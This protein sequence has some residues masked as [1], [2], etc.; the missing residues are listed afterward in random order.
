M[1]TW[2]RLTGAR[3]EEGR[4]IWWKEGEGISQRTRMNDSWA[5]TMERGLWARGVEWVEGGREK[6]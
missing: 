5:W 6:H 3:G 1:E 2:N 4:G